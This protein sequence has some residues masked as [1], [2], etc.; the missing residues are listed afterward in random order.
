MAAAV[1][2]TAQGLFRTSAAADQAQSGQ[3]GLSQLAPTSQV[4]SCAPQRCTL[5]P[6]NVNSFLPIRLTLSKLVIYNHTRN[7]GKPFL[8]AEK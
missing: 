6:N 5:S 7:I 8:R 4:L 2:K 3:A 1:T